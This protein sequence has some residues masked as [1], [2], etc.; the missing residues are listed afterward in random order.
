MSVTPQMAVN[1]YIFS[2]LADQ[3]RG[4][5]RT[6]SLGGQ[7]GGHNSRWGA[8]DHQSRGETTAL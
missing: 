8:H 2:P 6:W 1:K 7:W 3:T 4:S 5:C